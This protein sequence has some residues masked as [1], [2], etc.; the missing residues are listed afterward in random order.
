MPRKT[1]ILIVILALITGVLIFL[2]I[3]S[4]KTQEFVNKT[5]NNSTPTPIVISPYA[6][7]SFPT[8]E[9]DLTGKTGTQSVDVMIDTNGQPVAGIQAELSYDPTILTNMRTSTPTTPILGTNPMVMINKVDTTQGRISYAA[10]ITATNGEVNGRG[11]LV[12]L[13]FTVNSALAAPATQ[14]SFLPKSMVTSFLTP[15]SVLKSS[16]PLKIILSSQDITPP[17]TQ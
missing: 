12:T 7:L 3:R 4:D 10:G 1:T 2:A 15:D 9:I 11:S 14:I 17:A 16:T 5:L 6:T 13:S 8:Q